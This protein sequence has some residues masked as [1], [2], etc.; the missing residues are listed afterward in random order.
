MCLKV[1]TCVC[2]VDACDLCH[3]FLHTSAE[4]CTLRVCQPNAGGKCYRG[5]QCR[6]LH[7]MVPVTDIPAKFRWYVQKDTFPAVREMSPDKAKI[8]AELLT[9]SGRYARVCRDEPRKSDLL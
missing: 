1:S 7:E 3:W 4:L 6:F 8:N 5:E 9:L 2:Y